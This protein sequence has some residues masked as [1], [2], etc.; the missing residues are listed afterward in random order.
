[1]AD[2]EET[3]VAE[4]PEAA[5]DE[6]VV[7]DDQL[8]GAKPEPEE[9][10]VAKV[11]LPQLDPDGRARAAQHF[12]LLLDVGVDVSLVVGTRQLTLEQVLA[13]EEGTLIDLERAASDPIELRVNG[14]P[15]ARAEIVS[16]QGKLGARI[17]ELLE[18]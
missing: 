14:K 4:A 3:E 18:S 12:G 8:I 15:Y 1:M 5:A 16:I 11:E 9:P 7:D 6:E 2:A 17:V 13:V 10:V